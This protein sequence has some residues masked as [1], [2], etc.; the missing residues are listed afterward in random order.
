VRRDEGFELSQV[1]GRR[2]YDILIELLDPALVKF[3]FQMS[4][5]AQGFVAHEYFTKYPGR[6]NWMHVQDVDAE[7]AGDV[8]VGADRELSRRSGRDGPEV[9]EGAQSDRRGQ[10]GTHGWW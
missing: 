2:A 9:R 1:G 5:I 4:T 10:A 7:G 3:E 6:F 8:P